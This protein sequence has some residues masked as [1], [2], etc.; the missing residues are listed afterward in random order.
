VL[1]VTF[2]FLVATGLFLAFRQTRAL[3]VIGIF[4]L[5]C[6]DPV[7]F[8]SLLALGGVLYWLFASRPRQELIPKGNV[9]PA[10]RATRRGGFGWLILL[11]LVG[12]LLALGDT[13]TS[14]GE[15][16]YSTVEQG[17]TRSAPAEEV[18]VLHTRAGLLETAR[19]E[20]EE[21]LDATFAHNVLGVDV[22]DVQQRIRLKAVYKYVVPI[23]EQW[24]VVKR[25]GTIT[26]MAP[27]IEPSLPVAFDS[28]TL[29][30]SVAS[31]T[32]LL[33]P[34]VGDADL[35]LLER[36]ITEKLG[37][38]SLGYR[39]RAVEQSR[40]TIAEFVKTCAH[41][42]GYRDVREVRVVFKGEPIRNL[43]AF[44]S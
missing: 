23:G 44:A 25:D 17:E 28:A 13:S 9:L 5:L 6:I 3:G 8:G 20:T 33:V 1:T 4:V 37:E 38:K 21:M 39:D 10:D 7:A 43:D 27:P 2:A 36:T 22:G 35:E 19:I 11:V 41:Q 42:A 18:V 40:A 24:R 14:T 34:F 15:P 12:G 31:G 30:K 26:A 29:E 32:W 16:G